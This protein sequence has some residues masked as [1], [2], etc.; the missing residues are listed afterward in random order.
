MKLVSPSLAELLAA[1][2]QVRDKNA[3][4]AMLPISETEICWLPLSL[5]AITLLFSA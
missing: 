2:C 5:R 4:P 1:G 3:A